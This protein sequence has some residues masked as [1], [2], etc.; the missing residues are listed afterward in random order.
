VHQLDRIHEEDDMDGA[1]LPVLAAPQVLAAIGGSETSTAVSGAGRDGFAAVLGATELTG[2]TAEQRAA[3]GQLLADP[4]SALQPRADPVDVTLPPAAMRGLLDALGVDIHA[5]LRNEGTAAQAGTSPAKTVWGGEAPAGTDLAAL[6]A[7]LFP[8][9]AATPGPQA[10]TMS[11]SPPGTVAG[12]DAASSLLGSAMDEGAAGRS[13]SLGTSPQ[14]INPAAVTADRANPLV[15]LQGVMGSAAVVAGEPS[16]VLRDPV[17]FLAALESSAGE[18]GAETPTVAELARGLADVPD[19]TPASAG[20]AAPA[21]AAELVPPRANGSAAEAV[22]IPVG[23]RGWDRAFGERVVWLVGQQ[24]HAAEVK[25]NPPHLGPVEVRLSLTGQDATVSFTVTQ[26][27][28]RDAI[29]QAIPRL[30]ELFA[31]QQLQIV[32]VDVGQ[33]D[34]AS[35]ASQGDRWG[36]AGGSPSPAPEGAVAS[37][38]ELPAVVRRGGLPGLVDEYA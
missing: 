23:Q 21:G 29:E 3:L 37:G 38:P 30:R 31:E 11:S 9:P 27:A 6:L 25:L 5:P 2:L 17:A 19:S 7:M 1:S 20:R 22:P 34:A 14:S 12:P 18:A 32:N 35:Q 8:T 28:T 16:P 33:R 36:R 15:A 24:I 10:T 26:G 13:T 4:A